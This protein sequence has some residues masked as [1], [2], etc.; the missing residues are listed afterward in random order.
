MSTTNQVKSNSRLMIVDDEETNI[1]LLKRLLEIE[2][3]SHVEGYRNPQDALLSYV[4]HQ[5]DLVI[6]DLQMAEIDGF[7]FLE[8]TK[9][10]DP[11]R[12]VP[13]LVLTA[14]TS[15]DIKIRTL[16][17]G[18]R[19]F[20]P[21]PFDPPEAMARIKNLLEIRFLNKDL[22]GKNEILEEKVKARTQDLH[23]SRLEI[24]QRLSRAAEYRDNET[25]RHIIRMSR[26][27]EVLARAAGFSNT[28]CEEILAASPMHDIGKIGIPDSVLLKPGKL[29]EEEWAVM[30]THTQIGADIL[31]GNAFPLL[32]MGATI[33][34][35]H[36]E[37]WDG[38]GYPNG[39]KGE[40]I[41]HEGRIASICDVFDALRSERPYKAAWPLDKALDEIRKQSGVQ[42]DP[43]LVHYFF[44]V[45]PQIIEISERYSDSHTYGA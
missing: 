10:A 32:T 37:R 45:L 15:R 30:K 4:S 44:K 13:I 17:E 43:D 24:I 8:Q 31:A 33:A 18:A 21:K 11:A 35:T 12:M 29:N 20:L 9:Q 42:F 40:S 26:F 3:Y 7:S 16:K 41:P 34:L 23:D 2:G 27:C 5:P 22:Q 25:G 6:L 19:D 28:F 39:L 38:S 36:H 1:V 14:S